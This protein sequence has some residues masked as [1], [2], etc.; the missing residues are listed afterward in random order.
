MTTWYYTKEQAQAKK[1]KD[2]YVYQQ[3]FYDM[4]EPYTLFRLKRRSTK[5][6]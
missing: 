6:G 3:T 4:K 5:N 2:E 1:R